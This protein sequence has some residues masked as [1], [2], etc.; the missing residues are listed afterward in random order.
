[1]TNRVR[2]C[3][4]TITPPGK[5]A[6]QT[7]EISAKNKVLFGD[8]PIFPGIPARP[9]SSPPAARQAQRL[10]SVCQTGGF[11][12]SAYNQMNRLRLL[13]ALSLALNAGLAT[14]L[15]LQTASRGSAG[16]DGVTLTDDGRGPLASDPPEVTIASYRRLRA[17]LRAADFSETE[18]RRLL[19][20]AA[21]ADWQK[22]VHRLAAEGVIRDR[23]WA[24]DYL[25]NPL[26]EEARRRIIQ[27]RRLREAALTAAL[28]EEAQIS[29]SLLAGTVFRWGVSAAKQQ[30]IA[31]LEEDYDLL[32]TKARIATGLEEKPSATPASN[33][34]EALT[35][36]AMERTRDLQALLSPEEFHEYML[37]Y[38]PTAELLRQ[39]LR[40][41]LPTEEEFRNLFALREA[42]ENEFPLAT[43]PFEARRQAET[44]FQQ[45][46]R[47]LLDDAR[48]IAWERV[49]DPAFQQLCGIA[50][51]YGVPHQQIVEVYEFQRLA[52]DQ[53]Q[54]LL[55]DNDL[56]PEDRREAIRLLAKE[57]RDVIRS[58]LG[59]AAFDAYLP[60]SGWETE[61]IEDDL[62][63]VDELGGPE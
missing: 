4:A 5:Q 13:L 48:F 44:V 26:D 32:A 60:N 25:G 57:A 2:V 7:I 56:A 16:S 11:G 59:D 29:P 61:L 12:F 47:G 31:I 28:G 36:L 1:M 50:E 40:F 19:E 9:P 23:F 38:S 49:Q 58:S 33:T 46:I 20:G 34:A 52:R 18:I 53:R 30:A 45:E 24:A 39:E 37:R 51:R 43:T 27:V 6:F 42:L 41:F 17:A 15:L 10:D 54:E 63:P 62:L 8:S 3:R 55:A 14:L 21:L 22:D 35:L